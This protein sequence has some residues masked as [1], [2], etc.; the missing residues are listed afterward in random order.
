MGANARQE[1]TSGR[2]TACLIGA[3]TLCRHETDVGHRNLESRDAKAPK[4]LGLTVAAENERPCILFL[5]QQS[6]RAGG[7]NP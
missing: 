7:A 1:R 6:W 3:R 2:S 5:E 4:R